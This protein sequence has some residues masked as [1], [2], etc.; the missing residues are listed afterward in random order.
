[1][2]I[3]VTGA[4]GFIGS[5]FINE[6]TLKNHDVIALKRS[7]DSHPRIKIKKE[8][9]WLVKEL[10]DVNEVDLKGVSILVHFAAHSA[11]VPYDNLENCVKNN[12]LDPLSLVKKAIKA[13]V[14][15][16]VIAGSCFEY[17]EIGDK[18]DYIPTDA[19][20]TP[21]HTYPT[22]KAI[23]S[24]IF[25]QLTYDF[26]IKIIYNR[27]FQVY[28]EGEYENRLWPALKKAAL[29]NKN[30]D[31]THGEQIRDFINVKD[32]AKIFYKDCL[33]IVNEENYGMNIKHVGS[34]NPMS[35]KE[36][37]QKWWLEWNSKGK[38]NFGALP[39]RKNEVMRF[40]PEIK[41]DE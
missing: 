1:M 21:K 5:H 37:A 38:I 20:L 14:E 27:I 3:F 11:N 29:M 36:F 17:G 2:K 31:L 19:P 39:Y 41:K 4:T 9:K 35:I 18:Y 24:L 30:F 33:K 6:V 28:G 8:P 25:K 10:C 15:N 40:V 16:F 22:S 32:V 7:N 34:G 23:S 12:V 26:K 13:K